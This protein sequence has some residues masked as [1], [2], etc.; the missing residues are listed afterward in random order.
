MT[1]VGAVDDIRPYLAAADV[2]VLPSYR[3][4]IPRVAMEAAAVGPPPWSPTTSGEY[5]RSSTPRP[6]LLVPR[7]DS[8]PSPAPCASSSP[9]DDR[10]V[11]LGHE[12]QA[13][14]SWSGSPRTTSSA[15]L[16]GVYGELAAAA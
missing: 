9:T 14:G 4:G 3:E 1:F 13:D 8:R 5:A 7:G 6:A 2:V 16:R 11:A 10:R 12:C 15:R